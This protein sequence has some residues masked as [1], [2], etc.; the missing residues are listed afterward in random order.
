MTC[1]EHL[2]C[3]H[4]GALLCI[5]WAEICDGNI[6]CLNGGYDEENCWQ[7]EINECHDDEYRHLNG[8]CINGTL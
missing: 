5:H 7:L 3:D 2:E 6:D 1:Y 4:A 8:E